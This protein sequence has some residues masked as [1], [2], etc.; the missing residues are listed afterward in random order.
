MATQRELPPPGGGVRKL[1]VETGSGFFRRLHQEGSPIV[2]HVEQLRHKVNEAP[3]SGN[4]NG[5]QHAGSIPMV[6]LVGW[7]KE[8]GYTMHQWAV[9]EGGQAK[10]SVRNYHTDPGVKAQFLRFFFSRDYAKLHN[11]HV[12]TRVGSRQFAVPGG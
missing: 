7:L 10:C 5:W 11:Q 4:P 6:M 3:T 9:N 12:T 2:R 8:N 1:L